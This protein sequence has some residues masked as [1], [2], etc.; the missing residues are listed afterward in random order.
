MPV[1]YLLDVV[2][3]DMA[4]AQHIPTYKHYY[5]LCLAIQLDLVYMCTY[6]IIMMNDSMSYE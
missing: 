1:Q 2:N 6:I 4:N 3:K 5:I